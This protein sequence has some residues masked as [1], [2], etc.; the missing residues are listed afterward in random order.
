MKAIGYSGEE[1]NRFFASS[2]TT[3]LPSS[4]NETTEGVVLFPIAFDTTM[5]IPYEST[6]ATHEYVVPKSIPKIL[7]PVILVTSYR[8]AVEAFSIF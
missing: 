4:S 1:T 7:A 5:G 3:A 2:P 8:L 6:V